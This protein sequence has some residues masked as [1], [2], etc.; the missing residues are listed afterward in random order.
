MAINDPKEY[1]K[2][3][4]MKNSIDIRLFELE[5][6]VR[7]LQRENDKLKEDV[8]VLKVLAFEKTRYEQGE[9]RIMLK[10]DGLETKLSSAIHSSDLSRLGKFNPFR[11]M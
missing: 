6:T 9:E 7:Q 3:I 4:K 10:L 2:T 11:G 5:N 1:L 8:Q